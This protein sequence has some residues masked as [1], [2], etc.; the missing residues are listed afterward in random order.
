VSLNKLVAL[1]D[2]GD[3][4]DDEFAAEKTHLGSNNY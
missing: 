3:L 1:H 4:T 2:R